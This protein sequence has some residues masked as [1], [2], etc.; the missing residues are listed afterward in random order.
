LKKVIIT[1]DDF[2]LALP[3][4]EAIEEAHQK[5]VLTTA[6]LMVGEPYFKD[7]VERAKRHT[8]LRVGLHLTLVEGHPVSPPERIPDLVGSDGIFSTRLVRAG[9]NFFFNPKIR[10][11]LETEMR[12]QFE[13][14]HRAGLALDHVNAHNHMHLHPTVLRLLLKVGKDYGLKAVRLPNEPPVRA[15]KASGKSLG[16][17]LASWMFLCP[18]LYLMKYH[19][20]RAHVRHNNF[21]W[22]M[23]DSGAMTLNLALRIV[24]GLPNGITELCFHPATRRCAEIDGTMPSYEH[25]AEFRALMSESLLRAI[26]TAEIQRIAFSDL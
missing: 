8:T 10:N 15:W 25:E 1:G 18:W 20:H 3:I 21:F 6:S 16:P 9:F 17:R 2:G 19:L 12:A 11:Q 26:Q 13:A 23:A 4:N 14:F 24:A 7:A 5:G 22:G